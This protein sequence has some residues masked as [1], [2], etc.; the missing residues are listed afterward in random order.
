MSY[1]QLLPENIWNKIVYDA[2][3]SE[4]VDILKVRNNKKKLLFSLLINTHCS[5]CG[6]F[7]IVCLNGYCGQYCSKRCW[8]IFHDEEDSGY[9]EDISFNLRPFYEKYYYLDIDN[10]DISTNAISKYHKSYYDTY[11]KTGK[12][13]PMINKPCYNECI[14]KRSTI[15]I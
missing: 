9:D 7:N 13:W 1:I 8:K 15:K 11:S 6:R 14:L 5:G 2:T 3:I 12:V 4:L 10:I